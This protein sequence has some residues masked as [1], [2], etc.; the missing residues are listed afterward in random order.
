M[1][2][3][4]AEGEKFGES[5]VEGVIVIDFDFVSIPTMDVFIAGIF[6]DF[7]I[8]FADG[9][10]TVTENVDFFVL[11]VMVLSTVGVDGALIAKLCIS[12]IVLR[13]DEINF[14]FMIRMINNTHV[15]K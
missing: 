11:V 1:G 10:V 12:H 8:E 5:N 13:S 2:V 14:S 9:R 4:N 6:I 15:P 7:D 3:F